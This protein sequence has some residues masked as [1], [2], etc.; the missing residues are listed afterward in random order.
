VVCLTSRRHLDFVAR[1]GVVDRGGLRRPARRPPRRARGL[2]RR[3]GRRRCARGLVRG[4]TGPAPEKM[5]F[6][7]DHVQRLA[8][9]WGGSPSGSRRP[10]RGSSAGRER[11]SRSCAGSAPRRLRRRGDTVEGRTDPAT[12]DVCSW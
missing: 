9:R 2:R 12:G 3:R 8:G 6:A 5:F 10:G 4:P 11:A 7:P 1:T